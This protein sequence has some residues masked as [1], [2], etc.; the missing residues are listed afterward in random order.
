MLLQLNKIKAF[1]R[2]L[3]S[4]V[5]DYGSF[6][7]PIIAGVTGVAKNF[8]KSNVKNVFFYDPGDYKSMI[9][10]IKEVVDLDYIY[11]NN[12]FVKRF[13]RSKIMDDMVRSFLSIS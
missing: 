5:F 9:N 8:L 1:N 13:N 2:V 6:D 12:T 10:V 11:S 7:K 4:K 3:P